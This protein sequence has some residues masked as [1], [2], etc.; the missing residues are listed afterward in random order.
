MAKTKAKYIDGFVLTVPKGKTAEYK[1]LSMMM[2]KVCKKYGALEYR[3]YMSNDLRTGSHEGMKPLGFSKM[4]RQ[5]KGEMVWFSFIGFKS[6]KHRDE[7]NK[8]VM[9]DPI[10]NDPR[11]ISAPMPFDMKRMANGG[12]QLMID[13]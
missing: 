1:K 8:K 5:K 9:K 2:G 3:E 4:A 11:M 6:R 13:V 12:F 10:M 7:V